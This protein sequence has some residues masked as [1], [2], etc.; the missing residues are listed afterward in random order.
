MNLDLIDEEVTALTQELHDIIENDHYPFSPR[1]PMQIE[2]N[3]FAVG[4]G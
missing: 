1:N 2:R 3:R 4:S